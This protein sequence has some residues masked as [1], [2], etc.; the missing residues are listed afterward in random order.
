MIRLPFKLLAVAFS[1][2]LAGGVMA[3][4][5]EDAAMLNRIAAHRQWTKMNPEPVKVDVPVPNNAI[6]AGG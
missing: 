4:T 2:V 6:F 3:V 5:D 1:T